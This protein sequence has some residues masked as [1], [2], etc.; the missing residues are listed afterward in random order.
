M[1]R[2]SLPKDWV[3]MPNFV[4][5]YEALIKWALCVHYTRERLIAQRKKRKMGR[6]SEAR[7]RTR[8][9][10]FDIHLTDIEEDAIKVL[11]IVI[12]IRLILY[13]KEFSDC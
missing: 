10:K 13:L 1:D 8:Q 6:Y 11:E 7:I 4:F 12:R 3:D 5:M 9:S 2:F